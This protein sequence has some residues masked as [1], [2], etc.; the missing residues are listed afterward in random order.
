MLPDLSGVQLPRDAKRPRERR[1][2]LGAVEALRIKMQPGTSTGE[3]SP[4][5]RGE[6][7]VHHDDPQKIVG[8]R[9]VP[10]SDARTH[11]NVRRGV[12]C[13]NRARVVGRC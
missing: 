10:A 4:R 3:P 6:D 1:A 5:V 9:P 12:S 11:R 7:P 2:P 8:R 13:G